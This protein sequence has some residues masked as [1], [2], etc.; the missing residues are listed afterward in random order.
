MKISLIGLT[1]LFLVFSC[2]VIFGQNGTKE[3][4]KVHSTALEN[5][6]IGDPAT[7]DVTVYLP[8][9]YASNT[10][11]HY[12][13]LYFLHG[14]T[15][16]DSKWF[17]WEDHWINL[18]DILNKSMS[19]GQ[20]KEMIVVMP[21]AYNTFKGSFYGSSETTGDWET[22]IT[23]DLVRYIDSHYR[24]LT[25][26]NSR[27]LAGHSMG[28]YGTMRLGM[29]YPDV[30]S[31]IYLLSACCMDNSFI[32]DETVMKNNE[33]LTSKTELA[34]ASFVESINMALS[35]SW[36]PNP[37]NPPFFI[38][39]PFKNGTIRDDILK[40]YAANQI[41]YTADQY[42][43]NL[44]QL[45]AIGMDA[46]TEDTEISLAT[47]KL[48]ELLNKYGIKHQYKSYTGDHLNKIEDRIITKTLPFFSESLEFEN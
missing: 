22:F 37:E 15:D 40:K 26:R 46:G 47:R 2:P 12:P 25:Q 41:L 28:G 38:D 39:L 5:N 16:D 8:P 10:S 21:N 1:L 24:T 42:I 11:K 32:T 44:K 6:L 48:H 14:F 45:N 34:S 33:N 19:T 3:R 27:G 9:S 31:A 43:Y 20:A 29:K 23:K 4:I 36:A 35:S 30:Y 17:G 18:F 13:V 7:R